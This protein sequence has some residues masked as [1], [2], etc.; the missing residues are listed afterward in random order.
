MP[1]KSMQSDNVSGEVHPTSNMDDRKP[2]PKRVNPS[3]KGAPRTTNKEELHSIVQQTVDY[4]QR[5]RRKSY[6][7]KKRASLPN[8]IKRYTTRLVSGGRALA[9]SI[10]SSESKLNRTVSMTKLKYSVTKMEHRSK[11]GALIDREPA[12]ELL[13]K[14]LG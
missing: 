3:N 5:L 8:R 13:D 1:G 6:M 7:S 9:N 10:R 11:K 4:N 12:V 14:T 2:S